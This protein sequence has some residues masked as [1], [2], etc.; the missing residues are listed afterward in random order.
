MSYHHRVYTDQEVRA[1]FAVKRAIIKPVE[2][3]RSFYIDMEEKGYEKN[4]Y[5]VMHEEH[6]FDHGMENVTYYYSDG[7][8]DK[9]QYSCD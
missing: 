4:G 5:A 8:I 7:T 6:E 3:W 2:E 9:A 1:M